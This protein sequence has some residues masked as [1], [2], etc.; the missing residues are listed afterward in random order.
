MWKF[1]GL[2][3]DPFLPD[4]AHSMGQGASMGVLQFAKYICYHSTTWDKGNKHRMGPG[5]HWTHFAMSL[6]QD[7]IDR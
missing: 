2:L 3:F 1:Q 6:E 4:S 7:F 5:S